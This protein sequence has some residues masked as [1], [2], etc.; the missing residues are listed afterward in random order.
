MVP[1][2]S[3]SAEMVDLEHRDGRCDKNDIGVKRD[4]KVLELLL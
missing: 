1:G 3:R 4:K 2:P